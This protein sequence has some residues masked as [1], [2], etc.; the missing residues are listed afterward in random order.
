MPA[1]G[2]VLRRFRALGVPGAPASAGIPADRRAALADEL[3]PV[4]AALAETERRVEA[5]V[6][7]AG[8]EASSM[9]A[10]TEEHTREILGRALTDASTARAEAAS[11]RARSVEAQCRALRADA[12]AEA[13]RITAAGAE[14]SP[15]LVDRIVRAVLA[16]ETS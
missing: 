3:A 15:A 11:R 14:R 7:D 4:F 10:R 16:M 1:I 5:L 8:Q 2:D 13:A 9:A 12:E 6:A